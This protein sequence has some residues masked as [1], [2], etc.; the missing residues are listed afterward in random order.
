MPLDQ[1]NDLLLINDTLKPSVG[2]SKWTSGR[3]LDLPENPMRDAVVEIR[4]ADNYGPQVHTGSPLT[5]RDPTLLDRAS[6][7]LGRM[8]RR[9]DLMTQLRFEGEALNANDG[10]LNGVK[11]AAQQASIL[12]AI[13]AKDC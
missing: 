3:V 5:G 6:L 8:A 11:N 10:V 12:R 13:E 1:G 7:E 2:E 9:G 4:Q